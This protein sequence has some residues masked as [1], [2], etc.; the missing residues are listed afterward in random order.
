MAR[1]WTAR[2]A[3]D[4]GAENDRCNKAT[5]RIFLDK[6]AGY[7]ASEGFEILCGGK[8]GEELGARA[9]PSSKLAVEPSLYFRRLRNVHELF[10][11]M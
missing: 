7:S 2:N 4:F 1:F 9:C 11:K 5:G 6:L 8:D 3:S 10:R